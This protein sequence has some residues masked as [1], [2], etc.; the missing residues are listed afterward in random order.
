MRCS[1]QQKGLATEVAVPGIAEGIPVH[2]G[3]S[4]VAEKRQ[5]R[6][7][8]Q[9]NERFRELCPKSGNPGIYVRE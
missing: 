8:R 5:R 6:K 1:C 4:R 2:K 9:K 7:F 3:G